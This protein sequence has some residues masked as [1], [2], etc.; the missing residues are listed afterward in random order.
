MISFPFESEVRKKTDRLVIISTASCCIP[1]S[2]S[3]TI[4]SSVL[5][6]KCGFTCAW[7]SCSS[8]IC[9]TSCSLRTFSRSPSILPAIF[10]VPAS[11]SWI[12]TLSADTTLIVLYSPFPTFLILWRISE[13]GLVTLYVRRKERRSRIAV[14]TKIAA[15]IVMIVRRTF[16]AS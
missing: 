9:C 7:I 12:S 14:A 5:Y 4:V 10:L 13:I 2:T 3:H 6:R 1:P 11:S 8:V 16:P 15:H